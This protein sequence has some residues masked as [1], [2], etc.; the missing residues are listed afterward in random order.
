M[1]IS[2]R[3]PEKCEQLE[4]WFNHNPKKIMMAIAL[5]IPTLAVLAVVF[6]MPASRQATIHFM[7]KTLPHF[8]SKTLPHAYNSHLGLQIGLS[9]LGGT[10]LGVGSVPAVKAASRA[11]RRRRQRAAGR[12]AEKLKRAMA[13]S[14]AKKKEDAAKKKEDA[15]A[16]IQF[17]K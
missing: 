10:I 2:K 14:D 3:C 13:E 4:N 6:G 5:G 9:A 7:G 8:M 11:N 15:L 1:K 12:A 17:A 16:K